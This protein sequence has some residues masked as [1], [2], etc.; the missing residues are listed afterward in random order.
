[1]GP[2]TFGVEEFVAALKQLVLLEKD[3][4]GIVCCV[5]VSWSFSSRHRCG[6]GLAFGTKEKC[7]LWA[8]QLAS[9]QVIDT[10]WFLPHFL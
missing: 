10:I 9:L 7:S 1:M 8:Q 3:W 5:C 6:A 2:Q 4:C